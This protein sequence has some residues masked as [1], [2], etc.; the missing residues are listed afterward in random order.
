MN[1]YLKIQFLIIFTHTCAFSQ[2]SEGG[3]NLDPDAKVRISK[4]TFSNGADVLNDDATLMVPAG[5]AHMIDE[6]NNEDVNDAFPDGFP[7]KT[8]V[9][10][11]NQVKSYAYSYVYKEPTIEAVF[12]WKGAPVGGPFKAWGEVIDTENCDFKLKEQL[13]VN[14]THYPAVTSDQKIVIDRKIQ[15]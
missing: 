7:D 1:Q 13:L 4:V 8:T 10:K 14:D 15:A 11:P 2:E 3:A 12:K 5:S 6:V 9:D